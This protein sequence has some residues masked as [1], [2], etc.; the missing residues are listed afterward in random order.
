M[1]KIRGE[2]WVNSSKIY[3]I[4]VGDVAGGG[5]WGCMFEAF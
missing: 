2:T 3:K 4:D 1:K 5:A